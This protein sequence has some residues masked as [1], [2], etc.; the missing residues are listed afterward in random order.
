MVAAC[1]L[2]RLMTRP[3]VGIWAGRQALMMSMRERD[4]TARATR[5]AHARKFER[6]HFVDAFAWMAVEDG[7]RGRWCFIGRSVIG[8][9]AGEDSTCAKSGSFSSGCS[10]RGNV[11]FCVRGAGLNR[12]REK[13][14][15]NAMANLGVARHGLTPPGGR[16]LPTNRETQAR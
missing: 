11:G 1:G 2:V 13:L 15:P 14:S 12:L 6:T 10:E 9:T 16:R 8:I 7:C 3:L 4:H 5:P